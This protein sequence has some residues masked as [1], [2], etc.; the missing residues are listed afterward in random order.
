M[1]GCLVR[2]SNRPLL[3]VGDKKTDGRCPSDEF[4][5][6]GFMRE[7]PLQLFFKINFDFLADCLGCPDVVA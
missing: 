5:K 4:S 3:F 1:G 7:Y 6:R 2:L